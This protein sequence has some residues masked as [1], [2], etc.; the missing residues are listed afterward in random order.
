MPQG[1]PASKPRTALGVQIAKARKEKGL[2]QQELADTLK[3]S[4]RVI[5]YWERRPV[6][7]KPE[8]LSDLAD[9]LEVSSDFLLGRE[10][11]LK[12][13]SPKSKAQIVFEQVS[14]LPRG[15]QKIVLE[16]LEGFLEKTKVS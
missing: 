2:T 11:L 7:L 15:K 8:Q 13:S 1:R 14:Q 5:T 16:M 12:K 4:Q 6:A 9:A 10:E 3:V